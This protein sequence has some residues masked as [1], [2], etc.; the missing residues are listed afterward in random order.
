MGNRAVIAF[1]PDRPNTVGIY[2][3]W[4]GGPESVLAF[5]AAAKALAVRDPLEDSYGIARIAQIIGNVFGGT[6]SI[7]VEKL[8]KLDTDNGD[9][10]LYIVGPSFTL[11]HEGR[12]IDV[13]SLSR[14]EKSD[15]EELLAALMEINTP[16]FKRG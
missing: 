11:E 16:I 2:V 7:G 14:G 3:H 1:G 13:S 15:Y 6:T 10:G 5:M 8:S 12:P 4:N 9:N